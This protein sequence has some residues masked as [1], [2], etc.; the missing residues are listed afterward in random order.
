MT[1]TPRTEPTA[2]PSAS[3]TRGRGLAG[4]RE[5]VRRWFTDVFDAP[6]RVQEE[7]WAR[8]GAGDHALV[9]APT[10]SGKTLAAFLWAL[11]RL[12]D[13][14][15][16]RSGEGVGVLYV[17]PLKALGTDVERNLRAPLAGI[18]RTSELLGTGAHPVSVG[19][20]TGDTPAR[21][22]ARLVRHPPDV[23]ITTPETLYL[24][25]TS[26]ARRILT[27][28]STVIVDEVHAVAGTK[29]GT[30]LALSLERLDSLVGHDVQRI[31][32]SATV[33]PVEEVAAFLGGDRPVGVVAP[34]ADKQWDLTVRVP[35]EDLTALPPPPPDG[36]FDTTGTPDTTVDPDTGTGGEGRGGPA[37]VDDPLLSGSHLGPPAGTG[38]SDDAVAGGQQTRP[39]SIWP[40]I[41][42]DVYDEVMAA[43]ASLV[44]V[45]SRRTAERLT[46]R[47]NEI[48]AAHHDPQS[49]TAPGHRPPAQMMAACDE[50]GRAPAVIA[51]AHH[52]SVSKDERREIEESL[53]EGRLRC[54]VA[55][56]S[57][58]LG[59][60]MGLVDRVIQV[61]SPPSVASA[62]QRVGRAGHS[63]GAVSVGSVHPKTRLDLLH[64]AVTTGRMLEGAIEETSVPR[65]ALDVLA[66]HTVAA[67]VAAEDGLSIDQWWATVRR[68]RPYADLD[69]AL[70]DR[71]VAMLTGA[72]ASADLSELRARLV[73]VDGVLHPR[74]GA[75]RLA[76]T[77]GGT[78]PDRGLFGVFLV[79]EGQGRRVG[80][81]DEEMVYESRVGDVFTLGASSWQIVEITRDQVR[82]VPAAGHTGRLPFWNG[83]GLGRP[84]ELG[85]AVG[86]FSREVLADPGSLDGLTFLDAH[87]KANILGLLSAQAGATGVVPDDRHV[88]VERFHD[89]VGDW[90]VVVHSPWGRPVN[91]AWA[92]AVGQRLREQLGVD[93]TPM[94]GDDGM[95]LRV[96]D[97]A[98]P[99]GAD[100]VVMTAEEIRGVV[101][102]AVSQTALFAGRF[103]ECAAR[104]LLL[105]RR[106][107]GRR[108]PLWQQRLRAS[109]LLDLVRPHTDFPVLIEAARE[110][111]RDV[112]DLDALG[113][114]MDDVAA[115]RVTVVEVTTPS[116]SPMAS[117]LL[118]GYTG[119]FM[120]SGDVPLTER[121]AATLSLDPALLSAVLGTL[122]LREVLDPEVVEEVVAGLQHTAPG[123]RARDGEGLVD[124]LTRLGPVRRTELPDRL[125]VPLDGLL[126]EVG[127]RV[128]VVRIAGEDHLAVAADLGLLRDGLGVP[129]PPGHAAPA[130]GRDPL[131][132]LVARW[133]RSHGPFTVAQV[134]AEFGLGRSVAAQVLDREVGA[135]TLVR[136]RFRE[137]V[138][139]EELCDSRVLSRIRS[140]ALA[141]ARDAI[142]PVSASALARFTLAWHGIEG[143]AQLHGA[144]AV[145]DALDQLAGVFLPASAWESLVLPARVPD[146]TPAMLDELTATGEVLLVGGG[147]AGG[148]DPLVALLPAEREDVLDLPARP[149][150][151]AARSLVEAMGEGSVLLGPLAS[152]LGLSDAELGELVWR[153]FAEGVVAPDTMA[154]VRARLAGRGQ[155]ASGRGARGRGGG[156]T[157]HRL[158]P[159]PPRGR[160]R[161]ARPGVVGRGPTG[162]RTALVSSPDLAG[163][164]HLR[165]PATGAGEGDEGPGGTR[166][167]VTAQTDRALAEQGR[168]RA[169]TLLD[170][171]GVLTRQAVVVENV[172]GGFTALHPV[173]S[174][175]EDAGRVLRGYFVEGLGGAQFA[176]TGVI[177]QLRACSDGPDTSGWPSGTRH[178]RPV[179]L[180]TLD[181]ANPWGA[182]L[183]WPTQSGSTATRAAG[184]VVVL[185]D[186]LVLAHLTRGGRQLTLFTDQLPQGV[187]AEEAARLVVTA[188]AGVVASGRGRPLVV[189]NLNGE[190]VLSHP[191]LPVLRQA[192]ARMNPRGVELGARPEHG[193]RATP[194]RGP[195]RG[196]GG[197]RNDRARG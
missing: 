73:E 79:G 72:Y 11:D 97:S 197:G 133:A 101:T 176:T 139:E 125:D 27:D 91:A 78:I 196:V 87:S 67:A 105:P 26:S 167:P 34:P 109:Q 166:S 174:A 189:G 42:H 177:D 110:C 40:F 193:V 157:A 171:H 76:T 163:R 90:R 152:S 148:R 172:P 120:Y 134:A 45:N 24:L 33:R 192:G 74:P 39:V 2:D 170:R 29:R 158:R 96:P 7:T 57:L 179:V 51:R 185:A 186:G 188:M 70:L 86:R 147:V 182:A 142:Q 113:R 80:E 15:R 58:E 153:L 161:M 20:R 46:S 116:P 144:D 115:G 175:L 102:E 31:G 44:F 121:R 17:S 107:P 111:L 14:G 162:V 81:L 63:V 178:P 100:L 77:S 25:L 194:G 69:R 124:L 75:L 190:P 195:G 89:E 145:H 119:A 106:D 52:G 140:R 28:V 98:D 135:G 85:R 187:D 136:G 9:V 3:S 138:D 132:Q 112:Y 128:A 82:V 129:V 47:L 55:T 66:Q 71:V 4:F 60:D 99:P 21:E 169:E 53:R 37:V 94:A 151:P 22:R 160:V 104:A 168:A 150:D 16:D 117:A 6:T 141:R 50:V 64:A 131:T 93:A 180:A 8:V 92:L 62:L 118:F 65:N 95:V 165:I 88:L 49:L 149:E 137:G 103:R 36:P 32:L 61:E 19:V 84:A 56:S 173:L 30:H 143:P 108:S 126:A 184:S 5:P 156:S 18:T 127:D 13:P 68:S 146:Y 154:P 159:S 43:R 10:G 59:I 181:P 183:D 41:E 123:R 35:V 122:D 191:L 54:V 48:W 12:T 83:E 38:V 23:L 114:L 1:T 130:P 164:W 155:A